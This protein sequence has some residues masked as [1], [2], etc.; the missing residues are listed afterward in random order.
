MYEF[1][2][3]CVSVLVLAAASLGAGC[4]FISEGKFNPDKFWLRGPA[5]SQ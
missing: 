3:V 5:E 4:G 1:A 2:R